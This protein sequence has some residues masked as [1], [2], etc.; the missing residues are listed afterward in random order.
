MAAHSVRRFSLVPSSEFPLLGPKLPVRAL[1][2]LPILLR[3]LPSLPWRFLRL[4]TVELLSPQARLSLLRLLLACALF[5]APPALGS[6]SGSPGR[7]S[8]SISSSSAP[9]AECPPSHGSPVFG[10]GRSPSTVLRQRSSH[11]VPTRTPLLGFRPGS[12]CSL[13]LLPVPRPWLLC[14]PRGRLLLPAHRAPC[15]GRIPLLG[16]GCR[17]VGRDFLPLLHL[18]VRGSAP[19]LATAR[20][21]PAPSPFPARP[22]ALLFSAC[23]QLPARRVLPPQL[24]LVRAFF[25]SARRDIVPC[26]SSP[27]NRLLAVRAV[28]T[29]RAVCSSVRSPDHQPLIPVFSPLKNSRRALRPCCVREAVVE[30]WSFLFASCAHHAHV[31]VFLASPGVRSRSP[32]PVRP[33]RRASPQP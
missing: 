12:C 7:C 28:E 23:V 30:L 4:L 2:F 14:W 1:L 20:Q 21:T 8:A 33:R 3:A 29:S 5:S 15:S 25:S 11:G 31:F 32:S 24:P 10:P 13:V 9:M 26:R 27:L 17:I 22:P 18:P 6:W 19:L 16:H